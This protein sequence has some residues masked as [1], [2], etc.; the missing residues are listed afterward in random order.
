MTAD[1]PSPL[2]EGKQ[3]VTNLPLPIASP[4]SVKKQ[5]WCSSTHTLRITRRGRVT[6]SGHNGH[7]QP[8]VPA[9]LVLA[10]EA[11]LWWLFP[12]RASGQQPA[13]ESREDEAAFSLFSSYKGGWG[14]E[15]RLSLLTKRNVR[16]SR[17]SAWKIKLIFCQA[18]TGK[19]QGRRDT[20]S[21]AHP[22][23]GTMQGS[24]KISKPGKAFKIQNHVQNCTEQKPRKGREGGKEIPSGTVRVRQ[25]PGQAS[26]RLRAALGLCGSPQEPDSPSPTLSADC[27]SFY[28]PAILPKVAR[29]FL[30]E[31]SALISLW[32]TPNRS[33]HECVKYMI[34]LKLP[35]QFISLMPIKKP[36]RFSKK[37][38]SR[39]LWKS[40]CQTI[41]L[42][43]I[44]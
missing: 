33:I 11:A 34:Q 15:W 38:P 2:R 1:L 39:F 4:C 26:W 6:C 13:E 29:T 16:L 19:I 10:G 12:H 5:P 31:V 23:A 30:Q 28:W 21:I 9:K 25:Q 22:A 32:K 43:S 8:P 35:L 14:L 41:W 42:V 27:S 37:L 44:P 17:Y 18:V 20:L 3:H 40:F 7:V 24:G 36:A